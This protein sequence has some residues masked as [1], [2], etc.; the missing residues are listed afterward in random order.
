M[1][2]PAPSLLLAMVMSVCSLRAQQTSAPSGQ[3]TTSPQRQSEPETTLKVDV[4]LVNVFVTVTD[5][6]GAPVGG[7]TRD[8]FV[9]KEDDH[10]QTIKVFDKESALPLS[11]A[12][13]IDT[14]LSTRHDLPLEQA[15]AKRFAHEIMRPVDALSVYA[16][17]EYVN[18]ATRGYTADLKRIDESIDHIR[19]GAATA[20]YDAIYLAS[21]A[22]DHRKGRKVIVLITDGGDTASKVDYKQAVRAAEEAEALVYSIIVVPIESSAGR[23][24][25]G[26]HAL[27]QL[28][29]DTGGKYYYAT[30]ITQLDDAFRKIS[31]ELRTQYLLAYYPSQRASFSEFRR[32]EVKVVGVQDPATYRV[33]HRAGYYTV[34]SEF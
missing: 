29:E 25:G 14:S 28:S 23:E 18:E 27:I 21:R 33:R 17:S 6:H 22:L 4:N 26:E 8:N 9:L 24:T 5:E 34:K 7:L 13:A 30:S 31:D 10:D 11:I 1:R 16:F 32:I 2:K 19:V 12:L 3:S 15:S 20:L